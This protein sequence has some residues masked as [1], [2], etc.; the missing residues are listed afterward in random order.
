MFAVKPRNLSLSEKEDSSHARGIE[1][2]SRAVG[3]RIVLKY[4]SVFS[5]LCSMAPVARRANPQD[6]ADRLD[7]EGVAMLID[8]G[9]QDFRRRSS[10]A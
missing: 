1:P 2:H 9:P 3:L 6:F 8:E 5:V 7:P 4:F 10:S